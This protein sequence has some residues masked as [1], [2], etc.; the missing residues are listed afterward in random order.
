MPAAEPKRIVVSFGPDHAALEQRQVERAI[1]EARN[2]VPA[3]EIIAFAA[4]QWSPS[5]R[6]RRGLAG[7]SGLQQS[8]P[9]VEIPQIDCIRER[10]KAWR[11]K[12]YPGFTGTTKRLLAYWTDPS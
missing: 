12:G 11:E 9:V 8:R 3:P 4:F 1:E 10:V 6:L 2:L 5:R 7:R